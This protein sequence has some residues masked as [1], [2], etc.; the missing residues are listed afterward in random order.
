MLWGQYGMK[1]KILRKQHIDLKRFKKKR[2]RLTY[3]QTSRV[4]VA[5]KLL[6]QQ[7]E[8]L[9]I[10]NVNYVSEK[11]QTFKFRIVMSI[12]EDVI[13]LPMFTAI[14]A[15]NKVVH[16]LVDVYYSNK[17]PYKDKNKN[18]AACVKFLNDQIRYLAEDIKFKEFSSDKNI[19]RVIR[20]AME[21]YYLS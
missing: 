15:D 5:I 12:E 19:N 13:K 9:S 14:T 17:A 8:P 7:E 10:E 1:Y 6:E 21:K 2:V 20:L 11:T 4:V 3:L 18:E 16:M